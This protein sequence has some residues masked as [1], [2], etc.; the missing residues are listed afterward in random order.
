MTA[1][2][3]YEPCATRTQNKDSTMTN[4]AHPSLEVAI[5]ASRFGN[6]GPQLEIRLPRGS[7]HRVVKAE[8][9]RLAAVLEL[10]T[11]A[12]E[13]WAVHIE[14]FHDAR[15]RVYLELFE[16]S[17]AEAARAMALKKAVT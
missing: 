7:N 17:S 8:L 6:P 1:H 13:S 10:A 4:K 14:A 16:K 5:L 12:D 9:H 3:L 2:L 11:P 15:G